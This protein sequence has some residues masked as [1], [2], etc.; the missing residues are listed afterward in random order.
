MACNLPHKVSDINI[1]I[2]LNGCEYSGEL[3]D[4]LGTQGYSIFGNVSVASKHIIHLYLASTISLLGVTTLF[5]RIDNDLERNR[6]ID[7]LNTH[8]EAAGILRLEDSGAIHE[9][10]N[11]RWPA[12]ASAGCLLTSAAAGSMHG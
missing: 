8:L 11:Q 10:G 5:C 6:N 12:S 2:V 1:F 9:K 7:K 3:I 4:P